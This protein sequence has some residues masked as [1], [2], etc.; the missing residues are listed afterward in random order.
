MK[1]HFKNYHFFRNTLD[2]VNTTDT[3]KVYFDNGEPLEW[4]GSVLCIVNPKSS[5]KRILE[6]WFSRNWDWGNGIYTINPAWESFQV[7]CDMITDWGGWTQ[8]AFEDYNTPVSWWSGTNTIT[9]CWEFWNILWWYWVI[10]VDSNSKTFDLENIPYDKIRVSVDFIK[11][12]S[13]DHEFVTIKWNWVD[14]YSDS[15][16]NFGP[17]NICWNQTHVASHNWD[18]EKIPLIFNLDNSS[19]T[20]NLNIW[21]TLNQPSTDES[22]WIDN[23]KILIK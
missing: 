17:E 16:W 13:W 22:Y 21:T 7:Y 11:I 2:I 23:L 9:Q 3:Y 14:L 6:S 18:E 12:D 15:F 5:C 1:Y 10:S 19:N 4:T 20:F 8:I